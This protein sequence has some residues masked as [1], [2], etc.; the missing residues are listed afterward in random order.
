MLVTIEAEELECPP[1]AGIL[2]CM[3]LDALSALRSETRAAIAALRAALPL[4]Q[5][6]HG[7][8]EVREKAPNDIVTGTDVLVQSRLTAA[9]RGG[10]SPPA[11]RDYR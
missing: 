1:V 8:G 2:P 3:T 4:V 11:Y 10:S 7:A 5:Q 6:R 9:A